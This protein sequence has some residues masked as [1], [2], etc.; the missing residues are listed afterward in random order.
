MLRGQAP[1]VGDTTGEVLRRVQLYA[2]DRRANAEMLR[3]LQ[4]GWR[5]W[6]RAR[7]KGDVGGVTGKTPRGGG[8]RTV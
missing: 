3:C 6:A 4:V 7:G 2:E 8:G 1:F 5:G